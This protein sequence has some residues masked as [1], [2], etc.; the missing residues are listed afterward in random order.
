MAAMWQRV[1]YNLHG[2]EFLF[3]G[4]AKQKREPFRLW[5]KTKGERDLA[6]AFGNYG[7]LSH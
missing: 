6:R 4:A 3:G 1:F 7:I 2:V 5:R